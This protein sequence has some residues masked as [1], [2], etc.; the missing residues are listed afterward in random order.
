M[1]RTPRLEWI[2][3]E[4]AARE[5]GMSPEWVR[6]QI[7]GGRLRAVLFKTG[8]RPTYRIER[9]DLRAFLTRYAETIN[10]GER[11]RRSV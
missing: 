1:E 10:P 6:R 2:S 8:L 3:T 4:D 5:T 9:R 7:A 11:P